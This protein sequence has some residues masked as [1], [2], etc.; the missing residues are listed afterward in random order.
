MG[1]WRPIR[2]TFPERFFCA[3]LREKT[4]DNLGPGFPLST[5][6]RQSESHRVKAL[7][8]EVI[9]NQEQSLVTLRQDGKTEKLQGHRRVRNLFIPGVWYSFLP[10]EKQEDLCHQHPLVWRMLIETLVLLY[11]ITLF[12]NRRTKL[13]AWMDMSLGKGLMSSGDFLGIQIRVLTLFT[14]IRF[15]LSVPL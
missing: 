4:V 2:I 13:K 6:R 8:L 3:K 15:F 11:R 9:Q 12:W 5:G 10:A 1:L 14:A 7:N